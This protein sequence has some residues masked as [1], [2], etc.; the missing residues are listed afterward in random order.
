MFQS[1]DRV[2]FMNEV[3]PQIL[4]RIVGGMNEVADMPTE[5]EVGK[6]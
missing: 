2:V 3:D 4:V 5:D 1:A 6:N